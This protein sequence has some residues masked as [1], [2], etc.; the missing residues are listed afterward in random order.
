MA[1]EAFQTSPMST[2]IPK[3]RSAKKTWVAPYVAA[4]EVVKLAF[5]TPSLDVQAPATRAM[6]IEIFAEAAGID[7]SSIPTDT[8][9]G[10]V[11]THM[12][13]APAI[14]EATRLCWIS[15]DS[16]ANGTLKNTFRPEAPLNRAEAAKILSV[17]LARKK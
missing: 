11:P 17:I 3:N 12:P 15:G 10:D 16:D 8:L 9:Y 2:T 6:A 7:I 5:L 1:M 13:H 4:A 14:D